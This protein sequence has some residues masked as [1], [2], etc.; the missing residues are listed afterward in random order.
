M[1]A[2]KAKYAKIFLL[3][4]FPL[5]PVYP[6]PYIPDS[7]FLESI[8]IEPSEDEL[9]VIERLIRMTEKQLQAQKRIKILIG[10][11]YH[12]KELFLKGDQSKIHAKY[13]IDSASEMLSLIRFYRLQHL[14]S[15]E[16]MEEV[17]LYNQIGK[18]APDIK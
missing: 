10:Q 6:N 14:F 7:P 9:V 12:D 5:V 18:K 1:L 8:D 3:L 2:N 4:L 17:T 11:M 15:P 13:M 16:F